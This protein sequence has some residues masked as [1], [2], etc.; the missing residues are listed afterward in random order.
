MKCS[1]RGLGLIESF[2]GFKT[3]P[4]QDDNGFWTGGIGHRIKAGEDINKFR[5]MSHADAVRVL[6]DDVEDAET[7]VEAHVDVPLSQN[8]FDALTSLVFNVGEGRVGV[9]GRDGICYLKSG[10]PSTLLRMLN[11]GDYAGASQQFLA[12]DRIAGNESEGLLK[13]RLSEQLLFRMPDGNS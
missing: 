2:E 11:S 8:Q 10:K 5:G 9:N 1:D 6:C 13:R 12:W 7:A 4:Y 3:E